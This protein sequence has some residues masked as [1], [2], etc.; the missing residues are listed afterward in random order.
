MSKIPGTDAYSYRTRIKQSL[1][2][3]MTANAQALRGAGLGSI[4]DFEQ[5]SYQ[6]AVNRLDQA[7]TKEE[8]L[9]A[10]EDARGVFRSMQRRAQAKAS[11]DFSSPSAPSTPASSD[12]WSIRP[13]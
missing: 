7:T 12:G 10:I 5:R 8:F 2:D 3:A 6:A 11:G 4:S 13:R 9:A 1:G